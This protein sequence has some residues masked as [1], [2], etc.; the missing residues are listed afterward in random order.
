MIGESG[1]EAV[2][3]LDK[4]KQ[5]NTYNITVQASL[6]SSP[7]QIGSQIIEA[8]KIAERKSGQVFASA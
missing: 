2:I 4:L 7:A 8:I 6:V 1:A 3:P 5:G